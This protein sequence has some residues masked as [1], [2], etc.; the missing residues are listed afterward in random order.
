MI[1]LFPCFSAAFLLLAG[2]SMFDER[3][4]AQIGYDFFKDGDAAHA[5]LHLEA[6]DRETPGDPRIQYNLA[7]SYN[8]LGRF[9]EA[10]ST[11]QKVLTSGK[12]V[13]AGDGSGK[14][15]ADL[16]TADLARLPK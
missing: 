5:M 11:Y 3:S 4:E 12:D 16:A 7:A 14:T 1:R 10:K 8:R 15:L 2:C 13:P 6:A 9:A